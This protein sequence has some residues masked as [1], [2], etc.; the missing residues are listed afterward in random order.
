VSQ[1]LQLGP[2]FLDTLV[3]RAR[4]LAPLRVGV[5]QPSDADRAAA[6][7]LEPFATV[8]PVTG[9]HAGERAAAMAALGEIDALMKG[10]LHSDVFMRAVLSE[11]SLRTSRRMSHVAVLHPSTIDRV[12]LIS[13]GAVNVL[14]TLEE[15]RDILQNAVDVA[16]V[17][18]IKLPRVAVLA[19]VE[20]VC[21]EFPATIECAALSKMADRGQITG[22]LVDGPLA[23]DDAVSPQAAA[24]KGIASPVAGKADVLIAPDLEAANML[25]KEIEY[26]ASAECAEVVVGAKVPIVL[27]SR[28][29]DAK[30]RV[31]SVALASL[32]RGATDGR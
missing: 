28:A 1:A 32:M 30:T 16:R 22:A 10:A 29:D 27:T 2:G 5:V 23:L 14:P 18:G 3:A 31:R 20:T 13:D 7:E 26:F 4:E 6:V 24:A 21:S 8:I 12:V 15:K 19:A 25:F 11:R 17:I 9:E